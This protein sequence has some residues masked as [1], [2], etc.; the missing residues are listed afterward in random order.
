M[1]KVTGLCF[2]KECK[3]GVLRV[4]I[5][6]TCCALQERF[7]AGEERASPVRIASAETSVYYCLFHAAERDPFQ[8][9]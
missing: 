1:R 9:L 2:T 4:A 5:S 8:S 3:A 6:K 7:I